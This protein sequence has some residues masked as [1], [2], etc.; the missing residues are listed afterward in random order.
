MHRW[1]STVVATS[2]LLLVTVPAM[3]SEPRC[4]SSI[5]LNG[6]VTSLFEPVF[7]WLDAAVVSFVGESPQNAIIGSPDPIGIT[8]P[9]DQ[10]STASDPPSSEIFG[11]PDPI[12]STLTPNQ[13]EPLEP[14][15]NEIM[16][17]PIPIG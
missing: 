5:G 4:G 2:L 10:E 14:P 7:A 11:I 16:G 17:H 9:G 1:K 12:G 6:W 13:D 3:A 15:S 8:V